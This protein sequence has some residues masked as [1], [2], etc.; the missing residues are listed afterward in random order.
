MVLNSADWQISYI[1]NGLIS[2]K[3]GINFQNKILIKRGGNIHESLVFFRINEKE[4]HEG[5]PKKDLLKEFFWLYSLE[6]LRFSDL[7][8]WRTFIINPINKKIDFGERIIERIPVEMNYSDKQLKSLY[9]AIEYTLHE[10]A[11]I[12]VLISGKEK[13]TKNATRN[14]LDYFYKSLGEEDIKKRLIDLVI[15]LE[16]LF[17]YGGNIRYNNSNRMSIILG[18]IGG[19]KKQI[20]DTTSNIY[21]KRNKIVHG[22][23]N[24]SISFE[25]LYEFEEYLRMSCRLF[26]YLNEPRDEFLKLIDNSLLDNEKRKTLNKK[27]INSFKKWE[28]SKLNKIKILLPR[29]TTARM[30]LKVRAL[31]G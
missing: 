11:N 8:N 25:E 29:Q 30:S 28:K 27:V 4:S 17:S 5:F 6:A 9:A 10:Q 20:F 24:I 3:E 13:K 23:P 19:N 21:K 26:I 2:P 7:A 22:S 1:V 18:I 16:S 15:V 12:D 31:T 14:A